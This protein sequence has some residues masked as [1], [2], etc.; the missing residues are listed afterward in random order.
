[1]QRSRDTL[2][3]KAKFGPIIALWIVG[4]G[5]VA[6]TAPATE[7][8]AID[9]SVNGPA[10]LALDS[11]RYLY[12]I[13]GEEDKVRRIDLGNRTIT[14]IA[15]TGKQYQDCVHKDGIRAVD[16][17]L[18]SPVSLAVDRAGNV[19]IGEIAGDVRRVDLTSGVITTVAGDGEPGETTEGVAA[20]SAHF[21]SIDGLAIDAANN[22]FIADQHQGK[23]F[24]VDAKTGTVNTV[25]GNGK[26][27]FGGDGGFARTAS[28]RFAQAI[29]LN[30]IGDLVVADYGNCRIRRVDAVTAVVT[31]VA[32]TGELNQDGSCRAGNL[33]PGPY[34]SDPA[35]DS[36]GNI[37][38]V[39]GAMDIVLRVD[40]STL[41]LST[42]AGT[43]AKGYSGDGGPATRARLDNPSG[44]AIDDE[45]NL[46]IAEFVNNRV[47]RVDA[48]TGIITTIAGNGL[49]HRLDVTM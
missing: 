6:S 28:F 24:K 46:F 25:A 33:E 16:A 12:V 42:V 19:L 11:S 22:L 7:N 29:A 14:T 35:V 30:K 3:F 8:L 26:H 44:L 45:G 34:P 13:E 2:I 9:T 15:G 18:R 1:V 47:R 10:A 39:E 27:G 17:C 20:L 4:L 38:F 40:V 41:A 5:W 49:P 48:K 23:I 37:Y 36:S 31:T 21:W 43:G 32:T